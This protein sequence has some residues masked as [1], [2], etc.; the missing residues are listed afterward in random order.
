M[1]QRSGEPLTQTT[2][3]LRLRFA[4]LY[5]QYVLRKSMMTA[6]LW[7]NAQRSRQGLMR[8]WAALMVKV[9]GMSHSRR[10]QEQRPSPRARMIS[11]ALQLIRVDTVSGDDRRW[12]WMCWVIIQSQA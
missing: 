10:V 2:E 4:A 3:M 1:Q 11:C 9:H 12:W 5:V 7:E 6:R 8:S